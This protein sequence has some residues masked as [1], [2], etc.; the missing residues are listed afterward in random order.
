MGRWKAAAAL[1][2]CWALAASLLA[3]HYYVL[4]SAPPVRQAG[5]SNVLLIIDY[6]NGTF[7]LYNVTLGAPATLFNLTSR[8]AYVE[9]KTYPGMGEYVT[10][11]NGVAESPAK[12]RYWIWWYWDAKQGQWAL[13]PVGAGAFLITNST[14]VCWYY[15]RV[16][17]STWSIEPPPSRVVSLRVP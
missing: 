12:G 17:P 8:V 11:I 14:I 7:Y 10:A 15:S 5:L 16:D 3:A 6:A 1:A 13:G 9:Y 2:L 4:S